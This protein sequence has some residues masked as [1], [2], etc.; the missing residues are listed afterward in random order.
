MKPHELVALQSSAQASR[1]AAFEFGEIHPSLQWP[2]CTKSGDGVHVRDLLRVRVWLRQVAP[3][4]A[5]ARYCVMLCDCVSV[6]P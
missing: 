3:E 5:E 4:G 2:S 1:L 6:C